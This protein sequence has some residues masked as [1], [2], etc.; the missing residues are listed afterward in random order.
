MS[1]IIKDYNCDIFI[2]YL[3]KDNQGDLR[4]M[5]FIEEKDRIKLINK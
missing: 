2:S 4:A 3:Y 5:D 1:V